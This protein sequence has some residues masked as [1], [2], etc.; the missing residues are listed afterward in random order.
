MVV[1]HTKSINT[2]NNTLDLLDV[3]DAA[4]ALSS[5][6]SAARYIIKQLKNNQA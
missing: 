6:I 1:H 2:K 3:A 4:L 5:P